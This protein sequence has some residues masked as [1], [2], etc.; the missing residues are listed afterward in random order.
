MYTFKTLRF[1]DEKFWSH[2]SNIEMMLRRETHS[3][4]IRRWMA[5]NPDFSQFTEDFRNLETDEQYAY[6]LERGA[7]P[8]TLEDCI[9][10]AQYAIDN[11]C[12][13]DRERKEAL[14]AHIE[15]LTGYIELRE[16]HSITEA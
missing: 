1:R 10:D 5:N 12:A 16:K 7:T 3:R 2:R 6:V 8:C 14:T 15:R 9:A 4:T 11:Y 13:R